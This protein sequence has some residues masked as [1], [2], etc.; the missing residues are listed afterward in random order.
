MTQKKLFD[1]LHKNSWITILLF[2]SVT[3]II[4]AVLGFYRQGYSS[5]DSLYKTFQLFFLNVSF[6]GEG[7]IE[8]TPLLQWARWLILAATLWAAYRFIIEILA[9]KWWQSTK[10]Y[11]PYK[12]HYLFFGASEQ[13]KILAKDLKKESCQCIFLVSKEKED[14]KALF[15]EIRDMGAIVLYANFEEETIKIPQNID[16]FFFVEEDEDF[17][18]EMAD[19][20]LNQLN[21]KRNA[22][23]YI[24]T[25]SREF[26]SY[27]KQYTNAE[28]HIFN[29]SDLTAG[30]FVKKHPMLDSPNITI[31]YEKLHVKG[32]FNVLF[33]GFG[34]QGE[35]L[36]KKC[37]CDSQFVGSTFRATIIDKDCETLRGDYP[38]LF[39]ECIKHYNLQFNPEKIGSKAFYEWLDIEIPK[40]NRIIIALGNDDMN[41]DTAE[42]ITKLLYKKGITNTK[43]I[44]FARVQQLKL[45]STDFTEFGNLEEVYTKEV[46]VN[47]EDD[48]I[49]KMVNY[50]YSSKKDLF[51]KFVED[52]KKR[53]ETEWKKTS[54]FDKDSSRAVARNIDNL[55][56]IVKKKNFSKLSDAE[57][58]IL[59][60]NEHIRWN[61]FHFVSGIS[62]WELNE[63]FTEDAKLRDN[64]KNLLKHGCLVPFTELDKV[65]DKVN[66]IREQ[67]I[68]DEKVDPKIR[69]RL[70]R[71]GKVNYAGSDRRIVR[72]FQLFKKEVT[73]LNKKQGNNESIHSTTHRHK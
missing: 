12:N 44:V 31:D 14:D 72:H 18:M 66:E 32:E 45:Y 29:Q 30:Q 68:K 51:D 1:F 41:I 53:M 56:E 34:W 35:E 73:K 8:I 57:M 52:D 58:D 19:R 49:A 28:I 15:E 13:A 16:K 20:I 50:V 17:N 65:S 40:F 22:H 59:A 4:L 5:S 24:R 64:N 48:A 26:Y 3:G 38:V 70:I 21:Q 46:I 37:V 25:E 9:P 2:F 42:K 6:G 23:F 39:D 36:L 55:M 71:D 47:E 7:G 69:E 62:K 33:L 10:Q 43:K 63:I 61:A 11:L 67:L 27:I 54:L 60:E